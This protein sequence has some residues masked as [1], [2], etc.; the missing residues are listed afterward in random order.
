MGKLK[1][2]YQTIKG[3]KYA[4]FPGTSHR[5]DNGPRKKGVQYLGI[6]V[7]GSQ[8]LFFNQK[9]GLFIYDAQNRKC[10]KTIKFSFPGCPPL[11]FG[12]S[13]FLDRLLKEKTGYKTVLEQ[14]PR[15]NRDTLYAMV[16]YYMLCDGVN[17]KAE[18]WF[19]GN[20]AR[21]LYPKAK[22]SDDDVKKF[23]TSLGQEKRLKAFSDAHL[24]WGSFGNK[25]GMVLTGRDAS[26]PDISGTNK[27]TGH[28]VGVTYL[29]QMS[30]GYPAQLKSFS[31]DV[32]YLGIILN[33]DRLGFFEK[34]LSHV[35]IQDDCKENED[36]LLR[37][38]IPF[39]AR[40]S[41][42]NESYRQIVD[43]GKPKLI[44]EKNIVQYG[45]R[46]AYVHHAKFRYRDVHTYL[47]L[48][49]DDA[50]QNAALGQD[51]QNQ[52]GTDGPKGNP[53]NEKMFVLK[54]NM[55][56]KKCEILPAYYPEE[57]FQRYFD[58]H[59]GNSKFSLM[60]A[61]YKGKALIGHR[62]LSMIAATINQYIINNCHI[63]WEGAGADEADGEGPGRKDLSAEEI[64]R[65]LREQ[66][67]AMVNSLVINTDVQDDT[68][69]LFEKLGIDFPLY[70]KKSKSTLVPYYLKNEE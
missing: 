23:L 22:L 66:K 40:V 14:I 30:T 6:E 58:I 33:F 69:E 39:I 54:S 25:D 47:C 4:K 10:R 9:M 44:D 3:H 38:D 27:S 35:I 8:N 59:N 5:T 64:F 51:T 2:N 46:K 29:A 67:C 56:F 49:L 12:D 55:P 19:E 60:G 11:T 31:G 45:G 34:E 37:Y 1:L 26:S 24:E 61:R 57:Q 70:F 16:Q 42:E 15:L 43:G 32:T 50:G 68:L 13:Y 20:F 48:Y 36:T 52:A 63:S 65:K 18:D 62:I 21:F 41:P 53:D 7:D 28:D 17:V